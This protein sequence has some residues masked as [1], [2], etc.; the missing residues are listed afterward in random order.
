MRTLKPSFFGFTLA[1]F[2]FAA[3][4][5]SPV[6]VVQNPAPTDTAYSIQ[7]EYMGINAAT[8]DSEGAQVTA[9]GGNNFGLLILKG[10]L[11]GRGWNGKDWKILSG[12]LQGNSAR[13]VQNGFNLS[14]R[15]AGDSVLGS[16]DSGQILRLVKI[17]RQSP[18]LGEAPPAGAVVLF[19]GDSVTAWNN[20]VLDSTHALR[21]DETSTGAF[22]KQ[23]FGDFTL[24]MEFYLPF[25]PGN[26]GQE[27][28][29][30]GVYLQGRYELQILD[31][32]GE[33]LANLAV[34]DTLDPARQCG[35]FYE[36]SAPLTNMSFPPLTWQTYDLDF[37]A[38]K[39]DSPG[40]KT[41]NAAVTVRQNG[42]LLHQNQTLPNP[43][44]LGSAET[45]SPGPIL[46][47]Y[48]GPRVLFRN[49]WL[50]TPAN[51]L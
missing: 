12:A 30:S 42:I 48:H 40:N 26:S 41:Q 25:E 17:Q 43:T 35:A 45:P 8:G 16:N 14:I 19:D 20:A 11:P 23:L 39:W 13:F 50:T 27:R 51:N 36:Q 2:C 5:H 29:N 32:F 4:D 31:S 49:I 24:H 9:Q 22:T 3:C 46:L 18:T 33:S 47:Q 7:G 34:S 10:G 1:A 38:A 44:L 15:I 6:S 37:V 28:G 21:A